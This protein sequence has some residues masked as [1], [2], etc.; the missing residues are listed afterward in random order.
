MDNDTYDMTRHLS[1]LLFVAVAAA[2]TS[3]FEAEGPSSGLGKGEVLYL[4]LSA[5]NSVSPVNDAQVARLWDVMHSVA[6]M[7]GIV[8][9][10]EPVLYV[11][12]VCNGSTRVD[13]YWWDMFRREG[14]W[15]SGRKV[16][17]M[18]DP[19]AAASY[20]RDKI[21]GLVVYDGNVA[22]TSCVASTVAGVEN[23]IAVR[24][25]PD[26]ESMYSKLCGLGYEPKVWLVRED[27]KSIFKSKL[28]PYRW[29]IDNYLKPGK[30]GSRFAAY[31]I[32]QF[33]RTSCAGFNMNHHQL[34]NHDFF[35]A[36]KSFFFDLS[37]WDDERATD[38]PSQA[39]GDDATILKEILSLLYSQNGGT[40]FCHIGGFPA[41]GYKYTNTGSVGGKHG[42]VET[43]W[44]FAHIAGAY[45][46]FIDADALSYG[47]M[48]NASFWHH[49]PL[50]PFYPQKWT[51]RE[52][53]KKRG[54]L[55]AD[56][57]V[58]LSRKYALFYIG[59]YD[60]ASWL[61]QCMPSIWS[62]A[63]RQTGVPMMWNI[64]PVIAE[65]APMVM[66][67]LRK[68]AGADDYFAAADNGAGYLNP[69]DLEEPRPFSGL[70]S[71][72]DAWVA[73]CKPYY[74][75]WGLSVT[76]F[77]IDGFARRMSAD[78]LAC[79]SKFS[80]N[81]IVPQLCETAELSG[82]M[83]VFRAG[84]DLNQTN[85]AEAAAV[86]VADISAHGETPFHWYRSVLKSPTWY[87]SVREELRTKAPQVEWM[88]AP[89]FFELLRCY[90]EENR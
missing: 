21:K 77:I 45:N 42:A 2:C 26:P 22:S 87:V 56:G 69:G 28:E 5:W 89:S 27:G 48:A 54:Y 34:T 9:R 47:A 16:T 79:Y 23:L 88:D 66:H 25:D 14:E 32:D 35:V 6:T 11:D 86:V 29:A 83:P 50:E 4:N 17:K 15:L 1:P 85:A 10:G 13:K 65:R 73:H 84:I 24:F 63:G 40:T 8:N 74:E 7:Q 78:A 30:C 49:F 51:D 38:D 58:D 70:P 53:L 39:L 33:W 20:F 64:S 60:A 41:W 19:V 55:T 90:L 81:G 71:G 76:G 82:N 80:P 62:D 44:Q 59:D 46:A 37:P 31:Y 3:P 12:Y 72:L 18:N 68:T 43:E 57:K 67:Y 75:Q 52:T 61:Y 36:Q